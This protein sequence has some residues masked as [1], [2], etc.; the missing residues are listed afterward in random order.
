MAAPTTSTC[1]PWATVADVGAPCNEYDFDVVTL[2][3]SLQ[4]ASDVL[5]QLTG[6]RYSGECETTI[7]PCGYR[8]PDSCGCLSSRACGCRRLS[9][10]RLPGVVVEVTEVRIDGAVVDP[11]RY[12]VD[13]WRTLVYLPESDTADR[14]GWPCCQRLDQPD[15]EPDTWSV[16]YTHGIDPPPGGVRAAAVLGCQLAL[17]FNPDTAGQCRL[18][19]RVTAIT[20]QGVTIAVLD[21]LTLFADGI[22]GL[23]DVDLW[24]QSE[25][26]GAKRRSAQVLVPGMH[27]AATR[28]AGT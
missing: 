21:P 27:T 11:A 13:D 6:R 23:A 24:V 4:I 28:R 22:T 5:F 18:P 20:R 12:R 15:T 2:E 26:I 14:Q 1:A 9:E 8:Q 3:T 16:T 17:S 19:K 7:R 10:L 25:L